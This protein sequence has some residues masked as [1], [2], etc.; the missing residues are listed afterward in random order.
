MKK[1]VTVNVGGNAHFAAKYVNEHLPEF[2]DGVI[3]IE[4]GGNNSIIVVRADEALIEKAK[5][6]GR[7]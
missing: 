3:S 7:L 2:V 5:A 1:L 6:E 4:F